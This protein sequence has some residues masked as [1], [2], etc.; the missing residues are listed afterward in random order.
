MTHLISAVHPYDLALA[1]NLE[2]DLI[3]RGGH[4]PALRIHNFYREM[5][6]VPAVGRYGLPVDGK[7]NSSRFSR[8][9]T[10]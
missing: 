9:V 7:L 10:S 4:H 6:D 8:V 3:V 5:S 2:G 1:L